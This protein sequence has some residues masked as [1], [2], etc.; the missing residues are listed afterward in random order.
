MRQEFKQRLGEAATSTQVEEE[1]LPE[2]KGTETWSD[3]PLRVVWSHRQYLADYIRISMEEGE[4]LTLGE[5]R[6][7]P[8]ITE[9]YYSSSHVFCNYFSISI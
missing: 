3:P 1:E 5:D 4:M 2:S 7:A 9:V 6:A 8:L